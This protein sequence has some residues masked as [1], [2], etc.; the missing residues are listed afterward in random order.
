MTLR[1]FRRVA[2]VAVLLISFLLTRSTW[3]A[4]WRGVEPGVTPRAAVLKQFGEPAKVIHHQGEDL[5]GYFA[6]HAIK[7]TRQVI[8]RFDSAKDVVHRIDV[9]PAT[10]LTRTLVENTY[11]PPCAPTGHEG[12]CYLLKLQDTQTYLHYASQGLAV[13]LKS[14]G[15]TV[16][17]FV[18]L[19]QVA[20][21]PAVAKEVAAETA[22]VEDTASHA[23]DAIESMDA[24]PAASTAAG[25][26][27]GMA[28]ALDTGSLNE[29]PLKIGALVYL[30][31]D[32]TFSRLDRKT[33]V[34]TV[35]VP[36]LIDAYFDGRPT[37]R[38][39]AMVVARLTYDPALNPQGTP[40]PVG[41]KSVPARTNPNVQLDQLWL[42]F[43]V[44]RIAFVTVG[45]QH[46]K[47]GTG[48]FWS[49]TD[50]LTPVRTD[51]LAAF[52]TRLGTDMVK[53]S[54]PWEATSTNFTAVGLLDTAGPTDAPL[55]VGG[56]LRAETV[57]LGAEVGVDAVFRQ[58]RLPEYGFSL[59]SALGP[60]DV[61]GE[62]ALRR[63]MDYPLWHPA[64]DAAPDASGGQ[65]FE[66]FR[67]SSYSPLA[68][69]GLSY[70]RKLDEE[71]SF[72][73][74]A[75]GFYNSFGYDSAAILPWLMLQNAY[76]PFYAG[77]YYAAAY[78]SFDTSS[79][80]RST[81][82]L[83]TGLTNLSDHSSLVRLDV[84]TQVMTALSVELFAS[85]PVGT[86]GGEFRFGGAVPSFQL[87]DGTQVASAILPTP[88]FELGLGFRLKI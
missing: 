57:L 82:I 24:A 33:K 52:D 77:K 74:G 4:T 5:V 29:D 62:V 70:R 59:S 17:S 48:R 83:L 20:E 43:D 10:R 61:T 37:D 54:I 65:Q 73:F 85:T 71:R 13:F 58:N 56:A 6:S 34:D 27:Q 76:L 78:A 32:V 64:P 19:P 23:E 3:A 67:P 35:S 2:S 31:G 26:T 22:P 86:R 72:T 47:W 38:L 15:R 49:P 41:G 18:Y 75:E 50:F 40:A 88:T 28:S 69:A 1:P 42:N 81:S 87:S 44:Q 66:R 21:K 14:D 30:R 84:V 63:E 7:G 11:G 45:R 55:E 51:P 68:S 80:L 8:F 39:R 12:P 60:L 25:S 46:V 53:V 9:F 36:S 79:L 16:F